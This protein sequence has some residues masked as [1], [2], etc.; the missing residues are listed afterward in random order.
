MSCHIDIIFS[1]VLYKFRHICDAKYRHKANKDGSFL[2]LLGITLI[3][4]NFVKF[5]HINQFSKM[6][7]GLTCSKVSLEDKDD[8]PPS[9]S[10]ISE[11]EAED[12]PSPPP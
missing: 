10:L 6:D 7:G 9:D 4:R 2:F 11:S 12:I 3:S 1:P 5:Q 8:E